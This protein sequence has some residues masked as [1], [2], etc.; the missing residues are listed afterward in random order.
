MLP[1]SIQQSC[2]GFHVPHRVI[3]RVVIVGSDAESLPAL[4]VAEIADEAA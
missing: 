1:L 2:N 4:A 3:D